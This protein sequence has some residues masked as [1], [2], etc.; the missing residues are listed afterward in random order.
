MARASMTALI[1]HIRLLISDPAGVSE[2]FSDDE[3]CAFADARRT[4]VLYQPLSPLP[5]I[6]PGGAVSYL[7]WAADGGPWETTGQL[8]DG[9]Y[10]VLTPTTSDWI[11]GRWTF[12]TTQ[13]AVR[14]LGA[15]YD[16]NAAAADAVDAWIA[17][18]ALQYDFAVDGGDYKRSQMRAGL[19]ALRNRLRA[20]SST[21][22]IATATMHRSDCLP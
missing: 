11:G 17:K 9:S 6:A 19:E 21:G 15:R 4:D 1:S 2:I 14:I 13:S 3:L 8:L 7:T 10:N 16:L 18:V 5:S 20:Q 12:A 22:G